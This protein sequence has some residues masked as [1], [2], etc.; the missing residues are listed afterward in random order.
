MHPTRVRRSQFFEN[1]RPVFRLSQYRRILFPS[2]SL[3]SSAPAPRRP[4]AT[5]GIPGAQVAYGFD[6][7]QEQILLVAVCSSFVL[8]ERNKYC[9]QWRSRF[10]LTFVEGQGLD[11]DLIGTV[12]VESCHWE[13]GR[14]LFSQKFEYKTKIARLHSARDTGT[15]MADFIAD[16]WLNTA[17]S[18]K[19][20]FST[21]ELNQ[22]RG[23]LPVHRGLFD[24][25]GARSKI[26][27]DMKAHIYF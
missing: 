15:Q 27:E 1:L 22:I 9:C 8:D 6:L 2:S 12:E 24:W 14:S 11:A 20:Y 18:L 17:D 4:Y 25:G 21:L 5:A 7:G 19:D 26:W 23:L 13:D 3:V 10:P 16:C